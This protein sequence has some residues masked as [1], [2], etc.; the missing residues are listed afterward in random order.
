MTTKVNEMT[1][2]IDT[3]SNVKDTVQEM[4]RS[5]KE[6][7]RK[8]LKFRNRSKSDRAICSNAIKIIRQAQFLL[9]KSV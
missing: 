1:T 7:L 2:K 3:D 5:S 6:T 9:S 4:I 8:Y